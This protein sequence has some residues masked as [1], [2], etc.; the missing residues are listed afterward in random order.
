MLLAGALI[1]HVRNRD[2]LG[3]LAPAVVCAL[4]VAGYL[5]VLSGAAR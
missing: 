1:T 2:E 4:L 5:A 3:E